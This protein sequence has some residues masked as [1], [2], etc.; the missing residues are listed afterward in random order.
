MFTRLFIYL[1]CSSILFN[2]SRN[3]KLNTI[4]YSFCIVNLLISL[5]VKEITISC[6]T[7]CIVTL[8]CLIICI[9]HKEPTKMSEDLIALNYSNYRLDR[10][11]T[12]KIEE[13]ERLRHKLD[14]DNLLYET[15]KEVLIQTTPLVDLRTENIKELNNKKKA[16]ENILKYYPIDEYFTTTLQQEILEVDRRLKYYEKFNNNKK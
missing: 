16:L 4:K 12:I 10:E 8:L 2:I 13:I 3:Y 11:L 15:E 6:L 7:Q 5:F 9:T 1:I 14:V